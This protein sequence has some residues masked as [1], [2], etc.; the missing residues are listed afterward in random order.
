MQ[1]HFQSPY[2]IA[3]S[4]SVEGDFKQL[5]CTIHCHE[6]KPI[7]A[8]RFVIHHLNRIDTNSKLFRSSQLRN[9]SHLKQISEKCNKPIHNIFSDL[10]KTI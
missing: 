9:A 7:T 3:I 5:K 8:E 6:R 4:G 1:N 2:S 10:P